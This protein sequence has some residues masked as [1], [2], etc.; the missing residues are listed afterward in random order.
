MFPPRLKEV[1]VIL[2]SVIASSIQEEVNDEILVIPDAGRRFTLGAL[3]D[4]RTDTYIPG[5]LWNMNAE[6]VKDY[7]YETPASMTSIQF[8]TESSLSKRLDFL[9]VNVDAKFKYARVGMSME[10]EGSFRY[11][12]D[13]PTS[14]KSVK[15]AA[16]FSTRS[17]RESLDVFNSKMANTAHH[18]IF[19]GLDGKCEECK[20]ATHV[21]SSITYGADAFVSFESFYKN[22][23]EKEE[24]IVGLKGFLEIKSADTIRA[25]V[26]GNLN[27]TDIEEEVK[28]R[29]VVKV[30]GDLRMDRSIPQTPDEAMKFIRELPALTDTLVENNGIGV[31]MEITL[32][33][34]SWIDSN[35][36]K[37]T[38]RISSDSLERLMKIYDSLEE[39]ESRILDA[40]TERYDGFN[41]WKANMDSFYRSF[42]E[43]QV[44][45]SLQINN[46]AMDYAAGEGDMSLFATIEDSYWDLSNP[47]NLMSVF[48]ECEDKEDEIGN[49]IA[50]A[51]QFKNAGI[52]FAKHLSDFYAPTFDGRFERVYGLV[53]V[54]TNPH[55]NRDS[56]SLIRDF[57]DLA[58]A[59]KKQDDNQEIVD[60]KINHCLFRNID[61]ATRC[62]ETEAFVAIHFESYCEDLCDKQFCNH[63]L[64]YTGSCYEN[65]IMTAEHHIDNKLN[66]L[67]DCWCYVPETQI[68]Q[69]VQSRSPERLTEDL[70][71]VP[72]MSIVADIL[73]DSDAEMERFGTKQQIELN[74]TDIDPNT[75][76]FKVTLEYTE[77]DINLDGDIDFSTHQK[78]RYTK[79]K[80]SRVVL[81]DLWA[82]QVYSLYVA[83]KNAVGL[84]RSTPKMTIQVGH[85]M[86]DIDALIHGSV[87]ANALAIPSWLPIKMNLTLS[88]RSF[89]SL[90]AVTIN[91]DNSTDSVDEWEYDNHNSDLFVKCKELKARGF[92]GAS[93]SIKNMEALSNDAVMEL[94]VWDDTELLIA[95]NPIGILAASA[96]NCAK[97]GDAPYFC[98]LQDPPICVKNCYLCD[99]GSFLFETTC[100][101]SQCPSGKIY[102][103]L[104]ADC[105]DINAGISPC[106]ESCHVDSEI[107]PNNAIDRCYI[108][109]CEIK[110]TNDELLNVKGGL[111]VAE[112][113]STD[114]FCS[115]VSL[116]LPITSSWDMTHGICIKG[117]TSASATGGSS[118][119]Y[120]MVPNFDD[121]VLGW[122]DRPYFL[123]GVEH[124]PCV[125]GIFLR[126]NQ[127]RGIASYTEITIT[128]ERENM[129]DLQ[130][131]IFTH[132]DADN[133]SRPRD[134]GFNTFLPLAGA[135]HYDTASFGWYIEPVNARGYFNMNCF[136]D[137]ITSNKKTFQCP[138]IWPQEIWSYG[139]NDIEIGIQEETKPK[140][141]KHPVPS[142]KPRTA[143]TPPITVACEIYDTRT[144]RYDGTEIRWYPNQAVLA[145]WNLDPLKWEEYTPIDCS[146]IPS[147][148]AM[149]MY[150]DEGASIR[151]KNYDYNHLYR[152]EN[153]Q[154]RYYPS[155]SIANSWDATWPSTFKH[156]DCV[157]LYVGN[158]MQYNF[159]NGIIPVNVRIEMNTQIFSSTRLSVL[160][161]QDDG[162]LCLYRTSD[163]H[164]YWCSM[165]T[166]RGPP[167]WAILIE[168]ALV[169]LNGANE[170]IWFKAWSQI[171]S[172]MVVNDGWL[173]VHNFSSG[174]I[175]NI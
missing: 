150:L 52:T 104:I 19:G 21:V 84:G 160:V 97:Y 169:V 163:Y 93:C 48:E 101:L 25:E 7:I 64:N 36:A 141:T 11:L 149:T 59:H 15:Y 1:S 51:S 112:D 30:Y 54:G 70:P 165:V 77:P 5:R 167:Y 67:G 44:S 173:S 117:A 41:Y 96:K 146:T 139:W 33:P 103:P 63:N 46:N 114:I 111:A 106:T 166:N 88:V 145:S 89:S 115:T 17:I 38:R 153:N 22:S 53:I 81:K 127:H 126:P 151:C 24:I 130:F 55:R 140:C 131:C 135:T 68:M 13:K 164:S 108:P 4:A 152:Y 134:G 123:F 49:L 94:R 143:V 74:I 116:T 42:K 120:T 43:Y 128:A 69:F 39:S 156:M 29:T 95:K 31:P 172:L 90:L 37:L 91:T 171:A 27:I 85:R 113:S 118:L 170:W 12:S 175:T 159:V 109:G 92:D 79:G 14:T 35:A 144:Y 34:L 71:R 157:G 121:N 162:N 50:L 107:K 119:Q 76:N 136:E 16:K 87:F 161:M 9:D 124:T 105:V 102:C 174:F 138:A 78:I 73:G 56:I 26:E 47:F 158:D 66:P 28:S 75:Q 110:V 3:Y 129:E 62:I 98:P 83:G 65:N 61:N 155:V 57:V 133:V 82:G 45:L 122:D 23:A 60:P 137:S 147:G 8:N 168:G 80:Q 20:I 10:I 154:I 142:L 58:T 100:R 132:R 6:L 86:A 18:R 125:D 32:T 72:K 40:L 148:D 99:A 2:L